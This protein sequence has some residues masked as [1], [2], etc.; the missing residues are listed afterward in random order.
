MSKNS[1]HK[2]RLAAPKSW[3]I[4]RKGMTWVPKPSPGK[5]A[6]EKSVPVLIAMRDYLR[7]CD[8]RKEAKRIIGNKDILV[9]GVPVSDE[10]MPVGLMDVLSIPKTK[11]HYRVIYD[12][13]GKVRFTSINKDEATWK[14]C[15]INNKTKTK[16]GKLQLNLHDGR[17]I[18][19]EK[20]VYKTGDTLK[21]SIPEQKILE[22][23]DFKEGGLAFLTGGSHVGFLASIEKIERTRNPRANIVHFKE[24]FSTHI[25]YV[26]IVGAEVAAIDIPEVV[27]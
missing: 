9:D 18:L 1:K 26:F 10:K 15:R 7:L 22:K 3:A 12:K 11:A 6:I 19:V 8:N 23:I 5:H 21:I 20:D 27:T 4:R 25:Q 24:E 17:N 14:L 16:G 2:K 13:R